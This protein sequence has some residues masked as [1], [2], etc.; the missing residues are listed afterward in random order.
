MCTSFSTTGKPFY[1]GRN[2]DLDHS[3]SEQVVITPRRFPL[4]FRHTVY[5]NNHFAFLGTAAIIDGYPLYADAVNEK[6]L[7]IAGLNFPNNAFYPNETKKKLA[8]APFELI[9]Y[10]LATCAS[11]AEA[12]SVLKNTDLVNTP[13]SERVP[14]TPL[15]FHIADQ[16]G[17]IVVERTKEGL[18]VHENPVGVLTNNPPFPFQLRSLYLCDNLTPAPPPKQGKTFRQKP[19]SLGVGA[20]GLAGDYSSPSRFQKAAWLLKHLQ[21]GEREEERIFAYFHLLASVAPLKGCVLSN[22]KKPHFTRYACVA[23]AT[24]GAYYHLVHGELSLRSVRLQD[25]DLNA[26]VLSA[27]PLS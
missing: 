20:L 14:L 4:Q 8:L 12:R 18:S 22:E 17:S 11:L 7:S 25:T 27:F 5:E 23:N 10:L 6:G 13:F 16:S 24:E 21:T 2:L 1:F 19:F 26:E 3:F 15:H 9:P